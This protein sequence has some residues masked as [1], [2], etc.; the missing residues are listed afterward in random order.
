MDGRNIKSLGITREAGTSLV[1]SHEI[2][3]DNLIL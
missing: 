3:N 1:I 2:C